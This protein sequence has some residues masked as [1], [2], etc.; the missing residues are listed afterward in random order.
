MILF[1][2]VSFW[3][4]FGIMVVV[5]WLSVLNCSSAINALF[6]RTE[7]ESKTDA[8]VYRGWLDGCHLSS[9]CGSEWNFGR[10]VVVVVHRKKKWSDSLLLI[11]PNKCCGTWTIR[12]KTKMNSITSHTAINQLCVCCFELMTKELIKCDTFSDSIKVFLL[13]S[14]FFF[15]LL[16]S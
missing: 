6:S 2:F 12:T 9:S 15:R 16:I 3:F 5:C 14:D 8:N 10:Y 13:L 11:I 1:C 4:N 7:H